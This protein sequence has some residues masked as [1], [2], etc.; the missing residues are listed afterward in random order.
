MCKLNDLLSKKR[1]GPAKGA[2]IVEHQKKATRHY[3]EVLSQTFVESGVATCLTL[4]QD[5]IA[6]GL[7]NC[8]VCVNKTSATMPQVLNGFVEIA[9]IYKEYQ[10]VLKKRWLPKDSPFGM[11][12][13][14]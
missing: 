2:C 4:T 8:V 3:N 1:G 5:A 13:L 6:Y 10:L 7:Y 11:M 12:M 14:L 9:D